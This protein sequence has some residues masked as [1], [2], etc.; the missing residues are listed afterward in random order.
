MLVLKR[1][2]AAADGLLMVTGRDIDET[3][4]ALS[5]DPSLGAWQM[6]TGPAADYT[7]GETRLRI[8]RYVR[9][10]EGAGPK[11]VAEG[12]HLGYELVK[13]TLLRMVEDD[14]LDSAG[15][16]RYLAPRTAV[17]TVPSVLSPG[18]TTESLSLPV[19][20]ESL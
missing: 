4:Y 8:L 11:Q 17:P 14:Q 18:Q 3:E 19:P 15:H 16:G 12:T 9:D 13:K 6:L 1:V 2:R 20:E 10:N 5:F 7:L